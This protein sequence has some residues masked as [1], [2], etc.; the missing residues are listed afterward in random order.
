MSAVFAA[1]NK[2]A[3]A[4]YAHSQVQRHAPQTLGA[5]A[6]DTARRAIADA[7]LTVDQVDG[8][9]TGALFPTSG[10]HAI[11][12]GVSVVS[13][14]WI[15]EHLGAHPRYAAGFQ[16]FGQIP[17]SVAMAVNAVASGAAEYVLVHRAL[18]NPPGKY[19]ANPMT[20]ARGSAQWHAPQ[21]FFGPLAMIALPY[22][23]Y[24]PVSY[25]H[26]TLPTNREV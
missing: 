15:A 2:V 16:G 11:Q 8:F 1:R 22:N 13:A 3:I 12:D 10:A 5:L 4:G 18:H 17:G 25:T 23:E 7:G 21:G 19:H 9:V 20:H 24:L 6:V 26:L 14:N